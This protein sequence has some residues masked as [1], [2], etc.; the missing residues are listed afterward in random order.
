[1][2]YVTYSLT[3]LLP[4]MML[5]SVHIAPTM[6]ITPAP[7]GWWR[8]APQSV[9]ESSR[10]PLGLA[11][12]VAD[13]LED[14]LIAVSRLGHAGQ[15]GRGQALCPLLLHQLVFP[16]LGLGELSGN[17]HQAQVDHEERTNLFK[18]RE[19]AAKIK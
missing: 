12:D 13:E 2:T 18:N 9:V 19:P 14:L 17:D 11:E 5:L 15:G 3:S 16:L 7:A 4:R 1:M 10:S 8:L 6:P